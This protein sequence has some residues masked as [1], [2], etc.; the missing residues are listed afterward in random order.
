MSFYVSLEFLDELSLDTLFL[1]IPV[2]LITL[3]YLVVTSIFIVV[4]NID[5]QYTYCIIIYCFH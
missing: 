2:N 3:A 4:F 5:V 1:L